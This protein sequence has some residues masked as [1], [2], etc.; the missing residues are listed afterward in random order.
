MYVV[1]LFRCVGDRLINWQRIK[2]FVH[3]G[4]LE[5]NPL[6]GILKA[7]C[8]RW[9]VTSI[10]QTLPQPITHFTLNNNYERMPLLQNFS[11]QNY[12]E[13]ISINLD[14]SGVTHIEPLAFVGLMKLKELILRRIDLESFY[15]TTGY[16]PF[17]PVAETVEHLDISNYTH[18]LGSLGPPT[19]SAKMQIQM[20]YNF[21]Q[22]KR[23]AIDFTGFVPESFSNL[24]L[25]QLE[26]L[27]LVPNYI[28]ARSRKLS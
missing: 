16:N 4:H 7:N 18:K 27:V 24:T 13:L 2:Y 3:I 23:L 1:K 9:S 28:D 5:A 26:L 14:W 20:L 15:T 10:P 25:S 12:S 6:S 22:L 11:F 19:K 17:E 8:S 21:T